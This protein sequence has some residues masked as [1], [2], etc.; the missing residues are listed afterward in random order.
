VPV[1]R[2]LSTGLTSS[3]M[4]QRKPDCACGGGCPRC[5]E[6][7]LLQTK[8]K[9]SEPGDRYE[10][11]ADRIAEEVM[12]MPEPSIQSQMEPDEEEEMVQRQAISGSITPLVQRQVSPDIEE[13][14]EEVI[15]TKTID[16]RAA[17][18]AS[19][20]ASSGVPAI[21]H[22]VLNSP[23]QPLDPKTCTFM[24]SRFGHDFSQVQVHTDPQA[25]ESAT[26]VGALAYTLGQDVVFGSGQY[27]PETLA[28]QRLLAHE[29]THVVQQNGA[30]N[31]VIQKQDNDASPATPSPSQSTGWT[32][33]LLM[34]VLSSDRT[35]CLGMAN[36]SGGPLYSRCGSVQPPFCQSARVPFDVYFYIDRINN[37]RPQ[38]FRSP[39]VS[40]NFEFT[41]TAGTRTSK[42]DKTDRHP[43]YVAPNVPLEPSFGHSFP[44]GS[45]ESGEL[46]VQLKLHDASGVNVTYNDRIQYIITPCV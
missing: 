36:S 25:T 18:S 39:T 1:A 7:A 42:I 29:L 41:T 45:T 31:L 22:E 10:Q 33:D 9:I 21:V 16:D 28:G 30:A 27:A 44:I 32:S 5:Q 19:T 38:P 43:R 24:E 11:E 37:P 23:G 14:E 34:I 40:V 8:L 2:S 35:D 3:A 12:R 13:E 17:P 26:A 15:Q 20:P 6:A 4:L 46:S